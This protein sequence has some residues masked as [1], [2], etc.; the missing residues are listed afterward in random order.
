[1]AAKRA[2]KIPFNVKMGFGAGAL[3]YGIPFQMLSG[4]V[5]YYATSVLG[6][7]GTLTGSIYALSIVWDAVTDPI[8]GYISDKTNPKILFGRR[9]FYVFIGAI[10]IAISNFLLWNISPLYSPI[11]KAFTLGFLLI[12]VKT[13]S[14]V[15]TTPYLALGSELSS[16]YTERTSVQAF[17]TAYFFLG[18]MFPTVVGFG[19]FFRPTS[20]YPIGQNNPEAYSYLGLVSSIIVLVCAAVCIFLTYRFMYKKTDTTRHEKPERRSVIDMLKSTGVALKEAN[21]RNA[22]LGL[23]FVNMAMG[24]VGAVGMHTFTYT[25]GFNNFQI[26]IIFGSLFIM[27]LIAQPLWVM[28]SNR[29]EKKKAL[30]ACLIINLVISVT[31]LLFTLYSDIISMHYIAV[32]PLSISM[33]FSMGGAIAMPYAMISDTIDQDA[34]NTGVRKEGLF[35]GCATFMYKLSQSLSVFLVGTMIDLIGFKAGTIQPHAVYVKLGM[36]LPVSFLCC[37]IIALVFISR[38]NLS[39]AKVLEYQRKLNLLPQD[40]DDA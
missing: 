35:Y 15:L 24:V 10:G 20:A 3:S 12:L 40:G 18:F 39:R 22:S 26:A 9:L 36:I 14:T 1:M 30:I 17:R 23:L 4:L 19:F 16:D 37:F 38:Y 11:I 7:S 33:G 29:F 21:F 31:F 5:I 8:M 2:N 25:F 34:F 27:A 32:L 28:I 6:I 13:F